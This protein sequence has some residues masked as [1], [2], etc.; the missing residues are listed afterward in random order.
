LRRIESQV[1][2]RRSTWQE[3]VRRGIAIGIAVSLHLL[4][5]ILILRPEIGWRNAKVDRPDTQR[6]QLRF[7][8]PQATALRSITVPGLRAIPAGMHLHPEQT[9]RPSK[10][11]T[12]EHVPPA[13]SMIAEPMATAA[14]VIPATDT[15]A[16]GDGGFQ[17]R[18]R[19]AQQYSVTRD[20]PGSDASR[21]PGIRLIDPDTQGVRAVARKVQRLFGI[22][23]RHC[24]DVEVLRNLT[25]QE[26]GE[27]HISSGD[28]DRLDEEYHCNQPLGLNF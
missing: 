27:R 13:V 28:L 1:M 23:S 18:L 7:L 10:P 21:A 3:H 25:P 15:G 12:I 8:R 9:A 11:A 22:T 24:I 20:V 16:D 14:P 2:A 6:L 5:L 17:E 4:V 26:L 19:Q